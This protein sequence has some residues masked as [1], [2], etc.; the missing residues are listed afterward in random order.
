M[1]SGKISE[2]DRTMFEEMRRELLAL[3]GLKG[4]PDC[5]SRPTEVSGK[6]S[7]PHGHCSS[8]GHSLAESIISWNSD[9]TWIGMGAD[10]LKA[11]SRELHPY[12]LSEAEVDQLIDQYA[13]VYIRAKAA[14]P[15]Y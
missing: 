9:E 12:S 7:C 3:Q 1:L 2:E 15:C 10:K 6:L 8:A 5:N 14:V 13:E 11:A 4:C